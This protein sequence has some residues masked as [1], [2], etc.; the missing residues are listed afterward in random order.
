MS[1]IV[2]PLCLTGGGADGFALVRLLL[3][4]FCLGLKWHGWRLFK[5]V[6]TFWRTLGIFFDF[7]FHFRIF[8]P[9]ILGR[10]IR[11]PNFLPSG[12]VEWPG[13]HVQILCEGDGHSSRWVRAPALG[14]AAAPAAGACVE[15]FPW[16]TSCHPR[17][18]GNQSAE[19]NQISQIITPVLGAEIQNQA[20]WL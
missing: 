3:P 18:Q 2:L 7:C 16:V 9:F 17:K 1:L 5:T 15:G 10:R 19:I 8:A 14:T 12:T 6:Q 4:F 13:G 11:S 20:V